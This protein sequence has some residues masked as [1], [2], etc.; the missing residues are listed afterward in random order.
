MSTAW[1]ILALSLLLAAAP[2]VDDPAP[3]SLRELVLRSPDIVLATPLDPENPEKFRVVDILRGTNLKRGTTIAPALS[4]YRVKTFDPPVPPAIVPPPR[5]IALALLFLGPPTEGARPL[6]PAGLRLCTDDARVLVPVSADAS[7]PAPIRYLLEVR[8]DSWNAVIFQVRRDARVIDQL[9]NIRR[10]QRPEPRVQSLLAWVRQH[11]REFGEPA[12]GWGELEGKVFD[13]ILE[14]CR[15]EEAWA[16]LQ[17]QAEFNHTIPPLRR[18]IFSTP[19]GRAFLLA[20]I[21]SESTLLG[22]RIHA[23]ALLADPITLSP[24]PDEKEQNQILDRLLPLL[25]RDKSEIRDPE[26][27]SGLARVIGLVG[28]M[29]PKRPTA[30]RAL[31]ALAASYPG[32]KPGSSRDELAN[33]VCALASPER[34][35]ELTSNPP[36][37]LV[38]LRDFEQMHDGVHFWLWLRPGATI[39]EQPTLKLER[40]GN[41]GLPAEVR[42]KPLT[43]VNLPR[44]WVKGWTGGE[45]LLVEVPTIGFP[46]GTWRVTVTGTVGKDR[47]TWISEPKRFVISTPHPSDR[48]I[49]GIYEKR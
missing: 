33:A 26:F 3:P 11:G 37:V 15:I 36:G 45:Y 43:V 42:K 46:A 31:E 2:I 38:T 22:D 4:A 5:R 10:I 9:M 34:W 21:A 47:A 14:D 28:R 23:L 27:R 16:A 49:E 35:K 19:A 17:L 40:M 29:E 7:E 6:T 8:D 32:E 25:D 18:P 44:P 41:F 20:R 30:A 12:R 13:W 1:P 48:M 39:T 24:V